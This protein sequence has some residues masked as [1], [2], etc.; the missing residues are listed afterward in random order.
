MKKCDFYASYT[1]ENK[2]M[3]SQG[4]ILMDILITVCLNISLLSHI[5][6]IECEKHATFY[7]PV[8]IEAK[9]KQNFREIKIYFLIFYM[10][11]QY[12][13]KCFKKRKL[14]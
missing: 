7:N 11:Q 5:C 2:I 12:K 6:N 8:T 13:I 10:L 14:P 9:K 3:V 1:D 4:I